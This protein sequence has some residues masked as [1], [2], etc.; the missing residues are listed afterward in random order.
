MFDLPAA[1]KRL[2]RVFD[3]PVNRISKLQLSILANAHFQNTKS[4]EDFHLFI[5]AS[6]RDATH[7]TNLGS[8]KKRIISQIFLVFVFFFVTTNYLHASICLVSPRF[9][10]FYLTH[11]DFGIAREKERDRGKILNPQISISSSTLLLR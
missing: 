1:E 3:L 10:S 4:S 2:A 5:L 6:S 9:T 8:C 11:E 7:F